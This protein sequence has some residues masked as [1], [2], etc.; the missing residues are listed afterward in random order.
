MVL[1]GEDNRDHVLGV[2]RA[3]NP[4]NN[5]QQ[6]AYDKSNVLVAVA[7]LKYNRRR[8]VIFDGKIE[9]WS[10]VEEQVARRKLWYYAQQNSFLWAE[11]RSA[12]T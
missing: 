1:S 11:Y 12:R 3:T 8:V 10:V 7:R 5:I 9:L 6:A 4:R 2:R